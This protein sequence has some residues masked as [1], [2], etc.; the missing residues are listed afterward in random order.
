M[1]AFVFFIFKSAGEG[2][3]EGDSTWLIH[4]KEKPSH[5]AVLLNSLCVIIICRCPQ[6]IEIYLSRKNVH[7]STFVCCQKCQ[8]CNTICVTTFFY[9][10]SRVC[11][12]KIIKAAIRYIQYWSVDGKYII[13]LTRLRNRVKDE[14]LASLSPRFAPSGKFF[15][16]WMQQNQC[17]EPINLTVHRQCQLFVIKITISTYLV[18]LWAWCHD[19]LGSNCL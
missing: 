8:K 14:L 15:K 3:F 4:Y 10:I 1:T 7:R 13:Y 18:I 12:K 9:W 11:Q 6:N 16:S 2:W 17:D 19:S 5:P